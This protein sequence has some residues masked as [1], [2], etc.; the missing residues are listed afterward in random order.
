MTDSKL[1][2][3][4]PLRLRPN[5]L[6]E[7]I[8]EQIRRRIQ[9]GEIGPDDRLVD[10]DL[11]TTLGVSRMP[12]R[13]ALLQ[14]VNEG[15]LTGTTRGFVL[16]RL[17]PQDVRDIFEMRKLLEPRAAA[18]AARHVTVERFE[19]MRMALGRARYAHA[20]HDGEEVILATVQFRQAWLSAEPNWRLA[21]TIQRFADQVPAVRH[22]AMRDRAAQT[23]VIDGLD[24][25]LSAFMRRDA[26]AA[27][28]LMHTFIE[29]EE[30]RYVAAQESHHDDVRAAL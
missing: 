29:Q 6:R 8:R 26:D 30:S 11:A 14:L 23:S 22:G 12:V 17:S 21:A 28:A 16:P 27:A 24:R 4:G 9:Q 19:A 15:Y 25:L 2:V 20:A 5:S 10:V 7:Q 13:E 1:D 3:R 18:N